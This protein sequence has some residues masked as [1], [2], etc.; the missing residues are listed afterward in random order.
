MDECSQ[1]VLGLKTSS[2]VWPTTVWHACYFWA[3]PLCQRGI[4]NRYT[5]MLA[6]KRPSRWCC[7]AHGIYNTS[8]EETDPADDNST[9]FY[10]AGTSFKVTSRCATPHVLRKS[11]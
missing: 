3:A 4:L 2:C 7:V 11:V 9:R 6:R 5:L 1:S 8:E 10:V